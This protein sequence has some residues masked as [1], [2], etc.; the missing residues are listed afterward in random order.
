[1]LALV[2]SASLASAPALPSVS[3]ARRG[4]IELRWSAAG[5]RC[6]VAD[7]VLDDAIAALA[8]PPDETLTLRADATVVPA[9]DG[10]DLVLVVRTHDGEGTRTLHARHCRQL[11]RIAALVIALAIDPTAAVRM[12]T[13]ADDDEPEPEVPEPEVPEPE[14][15]EPEVPEQPPAP[16]PSPPPEVIVATS[17]PRTPPVGGRQRAALH[18]SVVVGAGVGVFALPHPTAAFELG[19]ALAGRAWR[20]ELGG[21][22]WAPSQGSS[23]RNATIS[24]DFQLFGAHARG[25]WVPRFGAFEL[26]LCGVVLATAMRGA[27]TGSLVPKKHAVSGCVALGGGPTLLWRPRP[28]IA[29]MLR[30][31]GV[32][33]LTRPVFTTSGG[34]LWHARGGALQAFGGVEVR[35][36]SRRDR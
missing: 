33:A 13:H 4:G 32:G 31:E 7:D 21:S 10:L 24:G 26:P 34:E 17:P 3:E 35:F 12:P 18:G 8:H 22:Y 11:G 36:A 9:G 29:L 30:V 15:P 20:S 28:R 1:M 6:P 23:D 5:E 14:V 2:L 19:L 27:G 16:E 25:C